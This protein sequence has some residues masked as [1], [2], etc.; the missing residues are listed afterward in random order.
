MK[1]G[2]TVVDL[3]WLSVICDDQNKYKLYFD[4]VAV[5]IHFFLI[6]FLFNAVCPSRAQLGVIL[7]VTISQFQTEVSVHSEI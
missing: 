2:I 3:W 7:D 6:W 1:S 4:L 5:L